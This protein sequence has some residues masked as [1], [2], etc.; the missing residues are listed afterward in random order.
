MMHMKLSVSFWDVKQ[1]L[2]Y[3]ICIKKPE[4]ARY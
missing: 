1:T 2:I 4:Q 3:M